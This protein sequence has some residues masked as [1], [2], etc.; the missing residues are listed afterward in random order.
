M[1]DQENEKQQ[2]QSV[3]QQIAEQGKQMAEQVIKNETKKHAKKLAIKLAPFIIKGII[4]LLLVT[5]V[6]SGILAVV[7]KI[8]EIAGIVSSS[9]M[10]LLT[11]GDNGPLSPDPKEIIEQINKEL[12]E[13]GIDKDGLFLGSNLQADLY[14]YK[15]M[16]SAL[17]TQLPYIKDGPIDT[18][19]DIANISIGSN[20][21]AVQTWNIIKDT[22]GE[23]VQGIV[24]I[25]R[26]T[27]NVKKD[28]IYKKYERVII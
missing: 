28:L 14:L 10:K 20:V 18:L 8:R 3:G 4:G 22:Y 16:V 11:T 26:Q 13:A 2:E 15:F 12:E 21:N 17:S 27:G 5:I 1:E 24:K 9:A 7:N 23:E 25:K 6:V 19:L